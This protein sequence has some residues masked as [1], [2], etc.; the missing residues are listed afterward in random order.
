MSKWDKLDRDVYMGKNLS[1]MAAEKSLYEEK[2]L[3]TLSKQ[4]DFESNKNRDIYNLGMQWFESGL[5]FEEAEEKLRNDMNFKTG[6]DVAKR[7][8]YA[9]ELQEKSKHR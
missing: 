9:L 3:A 4:R 2:K 1:I 8:S 6:F 7:R 5:L